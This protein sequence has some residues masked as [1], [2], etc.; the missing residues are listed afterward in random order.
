MEDAEDEDESKWMCVTM[1]SKDGV[2]RS[3]PEDKMQELNEGKVEYQ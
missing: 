3:R 2:N 1:K